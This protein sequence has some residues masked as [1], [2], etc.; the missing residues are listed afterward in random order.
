MKIL[1]KI[2]STEKTTEN[3]NYSI[4][5]LFKLKNS[6]I[7]GLRGL[8]NLGNTCFMNCILQTLTHIPT[9]RDY[10]LSDQHFCNNPNNGSSHNVCLICQLVVLFQEVNFYM[11][12]FFWPIHL[13]NF[14]DSKV[15]FWKTISVHSI[16]FITSSLDTS[17]TSSRLRATRRTR[18]L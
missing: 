18:K 6:S 11:I 4:L 10:F 8:I 12:S 16:Q 13:K 1:K 5:K 2:A 7:I 3:T 9:L 14:Y 15:L 17:Q